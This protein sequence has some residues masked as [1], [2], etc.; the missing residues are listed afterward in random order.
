MW[1]L[2]HVCNTPTARHVYDNRR[3]ALSGRAHPAPGRRTRWRVE[4]TLGNAAS[5]YLQGMSTSAEVAGE[6]AGAWVAGSVDLLVS[7][8]TQ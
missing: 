8:L 7:V 1:V 2:A 5:S 4:G 3:A 6:V